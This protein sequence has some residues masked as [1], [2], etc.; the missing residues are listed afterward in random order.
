VLV[1]DGLSALAAQ[2]QAA[3][4]L[5]TLLPMLAKADWVLAPICVVQQAR[6]ALMSEI[7]AI[8]RAQLGL[9]LIGERPG[10]GTPDSLGAYLEFAPEPGHTD[11]DRN[12]VSNIRPGG[13]PPE[14]AAKRI[15]SLLVTARH[16]QRSG[17]L[18]KDDSDE[19]D[20]VAIS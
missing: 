8:L 11:A 17:F 14:A 5:A 12:C 15:F 18:L 4:V 1:S 19:P 10:L 20:I 6:V 3:P 7:G 16:G 9:I 13:L 2:R